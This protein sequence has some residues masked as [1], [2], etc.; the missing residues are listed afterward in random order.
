MGQVLHHLGVL[1]KIIYFCIYLQVKKF[2]RKH[3]IIHSPT[4]KR[5]SRT[6]LDG[7]GS[8]AGFIG[9]VEEEG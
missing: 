4:D 3:N 1:T 9:L 6:L 5:L 8:C 7:L 2:H